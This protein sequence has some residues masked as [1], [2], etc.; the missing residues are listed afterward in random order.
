MVQFTSVLIHRD[1]PH[2]NQIRAY[3]L[4]DKHYRDYKL[5]KCANPHRV[6]RSCIVVN[7]AKSSLARNS[8]KIPKITLI[9]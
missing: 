3:L 1:E 7:N 8:E 4:N 2:F 5:M 9:Y 6:E